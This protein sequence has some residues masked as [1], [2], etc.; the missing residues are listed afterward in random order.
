MFTKRELTAKEIDLSPIL[1]TGLKHQAINLQKQEITSDESDP[2]VNIKL[3]K[4]E[5]DRYSFEKPDIQKYVFAVIDI[6]Q[7]AFKEVITLKDV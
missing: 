7:D 1:N 4:I 6:K 2:I 3:L 5:E